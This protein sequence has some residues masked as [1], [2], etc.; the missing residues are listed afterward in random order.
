MKTRTLL[1]S[2]LILALLAVFTPVEKVQAA[3]FVVTNTLNSGAGSLREAI[4]QA[5]DSDGEDFIN[6]DIP[7]T[8]PGCVAAT[9]VCTIRPSAILPALS[10]GG[11][12]IAGYTQDGAAW[13]TESHAAVIKIR[14]DGSLVSGCGTLC[15]GLTIVSAGNQVWGLAIINF[16]NNGIAIGKVDTPDA[17]DNVVAGN[18]L[19]LDVD[20]ITDR[21]NRNSG[22]FIGLAGSHNT[23]GGDFPINRN[24]L[25]GNQWSGVEIH[26]SGTT[27]NVVKGNF[28]GTN[29][30]GNASLANGL[31]GVR[32]YGGAQ[33]NLIGDIITGGR[34]I[35]SGNA[36][37]GIGLIGVGTEHNRV[38]GN[39][40]GTNAAGWGA[41]PNVQYGVHLA[42]G[43]QNNQVGGSSTAMLN[44]ISG[45]EYG[46]W[47]DNTGTAGN[48][49]LGNFLGTDASGEAPLGNQVGIAVE[50]AP[51]NHITGNL[52]SGNLVRG[53]NLVGEK[54]AGNIMMRNYIGVDIS[55]G[56]ALPN[57]YDGI[58]VDDGAHDNRVGGIASE[59]RNVISGNGRFG[60]LL[61][62][63]VD[64]RI[65]GNTIGTDWSG[66][67]DL[68]NGSDGI[69]VTDSS[70]R[71]TIGSSLPGEGNVISGNG[72]A[73]IHLDRADECIIQGNLIGTDA[74][75]KHPIG[76]RFGIVIVDGAQ[77][78]T[79][80]GEL[81]GQGNLIASS[82]QDGIYLA[83]FSS[84][85]NV[86]S[87]NA[88]GTDWSGTLDLG[89][90][91]SGV[92]LDMNASNNTIG[93]GNRIAFNASDGVQVSGPDSLANLITRNSIYSNDG[94]GIFLVPDAH[95]GIQPPEIL[96]VVLEGGAVVIHGTAAPGHTVEVFASPT[97]DGEGKI[98]L[99]SATSEPGGA[100]RLAVSGAF[101]EYLTVTA[102]QVSRGTSTFSTLHLSEVSFVFLPVA[103][104]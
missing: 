86:I 96:P 81:P 97:D 49:I 16:P 68:G 78:N 36:G 87:G 35:I 89:N 55:G 51:N 71:N 63:G 50:N 84:W 80:G 5:N 4:K 100:F 33:G 48:A 8:D 93:P 85:G 74:A 22:V 62:Q 17:N 101:P 10:G 47:I 27:G 11:T 54:T 31:F 9:G 61:S 12:N 91:E 83:T 14:I 29:A 20:G 99:G 94:Q 1:S 40:I 90:G 34:N 18:Y 39:Y 26:G 102:T 7:M 98:Y 19:G 37:S 2:L 75:G 46:I 60:I 79:I 58:L 21:G 72:E 73:G 56:A 28:I 42:N 103:M 15:N 23:V 25:S 88:I 13:A 92:R 66:T 76:N 67:L 30:G 3:S 95:D 45:N 32:I 82:L 69:Y 24:V 44:L 6:F 70:P 38:L 104:R 77:Q 53:I 65:I 57:G 41:L 43:A 64:N 59:E 52:I